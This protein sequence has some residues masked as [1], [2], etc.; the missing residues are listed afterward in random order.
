MVSGRP[1]PITDIIYIINCRTEKKQDYKSEI[2]QSCLNEL[3][4]D[5]K[6][7][8]ELWYRIHIRDSLDRANKA[9]V[10]IYTRDSNLIWTM[11]QF[12]SFN[13]EIST[14][15]FYVARVDFN[16][17]ENKNECCQQSMKL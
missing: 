15:G 5:I 3:K 17:T 7:N 8:L 2:I 13:N 9:R 10:N 1:C 11:I 16:N 12:R 14:R 6:N 4:F